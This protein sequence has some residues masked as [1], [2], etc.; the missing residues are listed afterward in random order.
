[1][2]RKGKAMGTERIAEVG[3]SSTGPSSMWHTSRLVQGGREGGRGR[4]AVGRLRASRGSA[5]AMRDAW[6]RKGNLHVVK[7]KTSPQEGTS[8]FCGRD[9]KKKNNNNE[10]PK[11]AS[12]RVFLNARNSRNTQSVSGATQLTPPPPQKRHRGVGR[13]KKK[14]DA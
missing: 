9:S 6:E 7:E 3:E 10:A 8:C 12:Y 1:M 5:V 11:A 4:K 2:G 13:L 14:K